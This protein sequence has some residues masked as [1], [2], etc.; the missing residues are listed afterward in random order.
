MG[1]GFGVSSVFIMSLDDPIIPYAFLSL[2]I[3]ILYERGGF[4]IPILQKGKL[5][6]RAVK[7]FDQLAIIRISSS[8]DE[9]QTAMPYLPAC[10]L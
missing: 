6:Y 9:M 2:L 10:V 5:C 7:T 1:P 4:N 3:T 8:L